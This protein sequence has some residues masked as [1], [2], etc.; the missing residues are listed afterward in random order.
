MPHLKTIIGDFDL[1]RFTH[2]NIDDGTITANYCWRAHKRH[3][4]IGLNMHVGAGNCSRSPRHRRRRRPPQTRLRGPPRRPIRLMVYSRNTQRARSEGLE[5]RWERPWTCLRTQRFHLTAPSHRRSR[6]TWSHIRRPPTSWFI[7][8]RTIEKPSPTRAHRQRL[9]QA[10]R[11]R[12]ENRERT[13]TSSRQTPATCL[14]RKPDRRPVE[15][16]SMIRWGVI[17]SPQESRE[18]Y[19]LEQ[20]VEGLPEHRP[21]QLKHHA[22]DEAESRA[23][24]AKL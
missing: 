4:T 14:P 7:I 13:C 20:F 9:E 16:C 21:P 22:E 12:Y 6:D 8:Y 15:C 10:A 23:M 11:Y 2:T 24:P 3:T 17:T 1:G 19:R 5:A 18:Y